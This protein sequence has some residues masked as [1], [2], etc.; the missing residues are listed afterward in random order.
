MT[1][2]IDLFSKG[3]VNGTTIAIDTYRRPDKYIDQSLI[4]NILY[5]IP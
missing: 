3:R 1:S 2:D 4:V 5:K